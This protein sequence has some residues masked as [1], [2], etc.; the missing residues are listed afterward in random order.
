M[1]F[2]IYALFIFICLIVQCQ[3]QASQ[4]AAHQKSFIDQLIGIARTGTRDSLVC[5]IRARQHYADKND[6]I[7]I[8]AMSSG[9]DYAIIEAAWFDNVGAV[10]AL[11]EAGADLNVENSHGYTALTIAASNSKPN[12]V[13]IVKMLLKAGADIDMPRSSGD[14]ALGLAA[15]NANIDLIKLLLDWGAD[16]YVKNYKGKTVFDIAQCHPSVKKILDDYMKQKAKHRKEVVSPEI[17]RSIKE[18]EMPKE[19]AGIVAE[20]A[21]FPLVVQQEE[22]KKMDDSK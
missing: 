4:R 13:T 17:M 8:N 9:G 1:K 7:D 3:L 5:Y 18:V 12:T 22:E 20:Y 14:T 15:R 11:I 21:D 19:L 10:D 16:P 6:N 2:H